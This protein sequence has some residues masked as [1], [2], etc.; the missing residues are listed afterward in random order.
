MKQ[1]RSIEVASDHAAYEGHF[2]SFPVLPG[3]VL[4][5]E[6]L[7]IIGSARGAEVSGWRIASTKF[8]GAVRPG[9]PLRI[10]FDA[11]SS[12]V[13]RFSIFAAE[14]QV[15]TGTLACASSASA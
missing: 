1:T 2:P 8:L 5:D 3:A 9:D 6:A 13:I 15:V 10:E 4:L 11:A 14:R 12:P 7:R